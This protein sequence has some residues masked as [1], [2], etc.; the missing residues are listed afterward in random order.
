MGSAIV[1]APAASRSLTTVSAVREAFGVTEAQ[2]STPRIQSMIDAASATAAVFCRR[3][4]GLQTYRERIAFKAIE[5]VEPIESLDLS[6]EPIVEIRSLA[7]GG[8]DVDLT[9]IE[10]DDAS[11][12]SLDDTGERD[13]WCGRTYSAIY[14]AGYVLPGQDRNDPNKPIPATA[15]DLPADIVRA[16]H[17]LIAASVSGA[18]RDIM[19]KAEET[20]G[21]G[22]TEFYV[23]GSKAALP[24]P[25]AET[26]LR[27]YR[28]ERLA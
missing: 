11:I 14:V 26:I 9:L 12:Y 1:L 25:E 21:V 16:V 18:D 17:L 10:H 24:H 3:T 23:Q 20:E 6:C 2:I 4:F 13:S 7:E 5:R 8:V 15:Q 19:I 27:G 22:R 28:F